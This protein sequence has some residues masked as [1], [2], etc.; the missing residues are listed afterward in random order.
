MSPAEAL[1]EF[2]TAL[3]TSIEKIGWLSSSAGI[4]LPTPV[5]V[6]G[7]DFINSEAVDA[8]A[9]TERPGDR[10]QG[11]AAPGVW[12][13][14]KS[15]DGRPAPQGS[16]TSGT[17]PGR[18]IRDRS[19]RRSPSPNEPAA[20]VPEPPATA[21]DSFGLAVFAHQVPR[22][23]DFI[24][25]VW[26][27]APNDATGAREE[28]SRSGP[29]V[30]KGSRTPIRAPTGSSVTLRLRLDGFRLEDPPFDFFIWD[31][32]RMNVAF[33]VE[34]PDTLA[35]GTYVGSIAV[36]LGGTLLSR[37]YFRIRVMGNLRLR[38]EHLPTTVMRFGS[39]FAS[40]ASEDRSEV[41]RVVRG[42]VLAGVDVFVDVLSLRTGLQW[43]AQLERDIEAKELFYLFW[44]QRGAASTEVEHEWRIA[45]EHKGL[46]RIWSI[47]LEPPNEVPP[48]PEL[49]DLHFNDSYLARIAVSQ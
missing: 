31:G 33:Q 32:Q 3:T 10:P 40:Y 8:P 37:V 44:S 46:D 4:K 28:A 15:R 5:E 18:R 41:L 38:L 24:L 39:A 16:A 20:P 12:S 48:P 2:A 19:R 42:C 36:E 7:F 17:H 6:P 23:S 30:Q 11:P 27:F 34:V 47:P 21:T 35:E 14:R 22:G 45:L 1:Q 13:G 9:P 29:Q 43:R 49:A 25:E 26:A